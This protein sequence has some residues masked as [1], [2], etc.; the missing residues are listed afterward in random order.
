MADGDKVFAMRFTLLVMCA[1][2]ATRAESQA[3]LDSTASL[4]VQLVRENSS[5]PPG[6]TRGIARMLDPMFRE[7]G[8]EVDVIPTPDS[9]KV[10]FVARLRGSGARRP[11]LIAAHTDVVGVEREKWSVDP[12]AGVVKDGYVYGRGAIDFKGGVAVFAR[13]TM[14][15]AERKVPLDRD[16]IFLAEADE[17]GALPYSAAWLAEHHWP[18]ID[19]EFALNEGGWIIQ[20]DDRRVRYVSISTA[21]KGVFVINLVSHGTSTHSSMPVPDNAIYSLGRAL[22]RLADYET[23]VTLTPETRQFFLT[24]AK[25]STGATAQALRD[26]VNGGGQRRARADREISRDPLLHALAHTTIAPVIVNGG[27]RSNVIPGSAQVM[28]NVRAIP[29]TKPEDIA[30]AIRRAIA[31]TTVEVQLQVFAQRPI[32][33]SPDTTALY[34]ALAAAAKAEFPEAEVTSYLFQAGTDAAAWRA[35]GVPV[36]GIYPYPIT[37]E[38]LKRMHGN[39]ERVSIESLRRGTEMIY[40][41]LVDVAGRK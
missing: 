14:L 2:L 8:F 21:D 27:F 6:D 23:P 41:T 22:A 18:K 32:P 11:V 15:L 24:L 35:R 25:T 39:D 33:V 28:L 40:R 10:H 36:Y 38:D 29:G 5:N 12:F 31:D 37:A 34:R 16:V 17:E 19:A 3:P 7:R 9:L 20:R 13:A 26:L 4:L 30:A 1:A